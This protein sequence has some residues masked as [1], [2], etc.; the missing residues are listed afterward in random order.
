[1]EEWVYV[2]IIRF[3]D[4]DRPN[5]LDVI[6]TKELSGASR[7]YKVPLIDKECAKIDSVETKQQGA[8]GMQWGWNLI[9]ER[10]LTKMTFPPG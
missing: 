3:I 9:W 6:V 8:K 10:K 7:R 4:I 2:K 5:S 1:M